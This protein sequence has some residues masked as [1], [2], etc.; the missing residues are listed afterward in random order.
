MI[1]V[2][3]IGQH[4][5]RGQ[6]PALAATKTYAYHL[7]VLAIVWL[8]VH[9]LLAWQ[10]GIRNLYDANVYIQAADFLVREGRLEHVQYIFYAVP[11]TF[12]A[13]FRSVF[14]GQITPFLIFLLFGICNVEHHIK[15]DFKSNK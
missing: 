6:A 3:T 14:E 4:N 1:A 11:I 15:Q 13:L 5:Q 10:F 8:V 2:N 12:I 9:V 7:I